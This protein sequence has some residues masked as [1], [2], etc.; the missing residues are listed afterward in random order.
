MHLSE[1]FG[2]FIV[3]VTVDSVAEIPKHLLSITTADRN[4]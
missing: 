4:T 1:R 3:T 2:K